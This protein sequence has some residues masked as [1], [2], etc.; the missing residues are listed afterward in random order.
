MGKDEIIELSKVN[1]IYKK[2]SIE[3]PQVLINMEILIENYFDL[4]LNYHNP[5]RFILT[6]NN[7][8]RNIFYFIDVSKKN[9]LSK[10]TWLKDAMA[11]TFDKNR[12]KIIMHKKIRNLA[13][14]EKLIVP[15]DN[16]I[17]F[18]VYRIIRSSECILKIG[19]GNNEN[20]K[21]LNNY[22]YMPTERIFHKVLFLHDVL[23]IDN[24]HTSISECLG[25]TRNWFAD[26]SYQYNGE[27]K[28]RHINLFIEISK[29][30][31]ILVNTVGEY[32]ANTLGKK[33]KPLLLCEQKG[34]NFINT[35]LEIDMY[36]EL[37]KKWWGNTNIK[38]FNYSY[39]MEYEQNVRHNLR[40]DL[41]SNVFNNIIKDKTKYKCLLKE[42]SE[43]N[44]SFF[45]ENQEKY[46]EYIRFLLFNH[47]SLKECYSSML[48]VPKSNIFSL[49]MS[50]RKN[51]EYYIENIDSHFDE[52][53]NKEINVGLK[54]LNSGIRELYKELIKIDENY[55]KRK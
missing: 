42:Y 16:S 34:Y 54:K 55:K 3:S 50:L 1:P 43:V 35:V 11:N 2:M 7:I 31:D 39:L 41:Y 45:Q 24:E 6:Y 4:A 14:H 47:L 20:K 44:I 28:K 36:P 5:K 51:I 25:I 52:K 13:T 46:E 18:G 29:L 22:L 12:E 19:M 48:L 33:Y 8:I 53:D 23:F 30:I 10:N 38:P 21:V 17:E 32:Y 26:V 9:P 49:A 40:A 37:F 15:D 27:N